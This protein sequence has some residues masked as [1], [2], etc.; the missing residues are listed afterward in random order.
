MVL[1]ALVLLAILASGNERSASREQHRAVALKIGAFRDGFR[2]CGRRGPEGITASWELK[3]FEVN[4]IDKA[5]I[6]HFD[7]AGPSEKPSL[8]LSEHQ[9]QYLG[10]VR[11]G[12][13]MVYV[14]AFPSS[15]RAGVVKARDQFVEECP[16]RFLCWGIEYDTSSLTFLNFTPD[17]RLCHHEPF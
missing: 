13:R 15:F 7:H 10:F 14:N 9:R 2:L 6:I 17:S 3:Q 4:R 12:R 8:P 11:D 1:K 16:R 5:L